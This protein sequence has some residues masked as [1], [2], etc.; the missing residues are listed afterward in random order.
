[1]IIISWRRFSPLCLIHAPHIIFTCI[2]SILCL[3]KGCFL[4]DLF[5]VAIRKLLLVHYYISNSYE[6]P[7]LFI[8]ICQTHKN[9]YIGLWFRYVYC[10]KSHKS[11]NNIWGYDWGNTKEKIFWPYPVWRHIIFL[12]QIAYNHQILSKVFQN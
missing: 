3:C 4:Y 1:M 9:S 7:I 12:I 10:I 11:N 6:S 5:K 2:Q 8:N